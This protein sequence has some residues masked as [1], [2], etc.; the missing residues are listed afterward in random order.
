[1]PDRSA[2]MDGFLAAA[3]WAEARREALA[4]DASARRYIRLYHGEMRAILMD[5]DPATGEDT[6]PFLRIARHL[7]G[8]GLS[9]P[10]ILAE[11]PETGFL[12]L[13]DLGDGLF[14]RLCEGDPSS[15]PMLYEAAAEMLHQLHQAQPPDLVQATPALLA[16]MLD[17]FFDAYLPAIGASVDRMA[18]HQAMLTALMAHADDTSVL[19]LRDFHAENL[20]WLPTRDGTRRCGLLD[21]QDALAGHPGYDLISLLQD[22]RRDVSPAANEAA[23]TRYITLSGRD[24]DTFLASLA[25]LGAQR[26]LRILGIF[27]RL[28]QARGKPGYIDLVPRVW[29]HLQADLSHPALAALRGA[30]AG[31]PAPT[32][33]ILARMRP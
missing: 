3:G 20:I 16:Q 32:S 6:R 23:L 11:E 30:L 26:N 12:L 4:G 13:E 19:V 25:T 33:D 17:P 2:L 1:M 21:F 24:R 29:S 18:V 27:A 15:E 8:L 10:A 22:A 5:A 31:L 28:A 14:A 9:S 7:A